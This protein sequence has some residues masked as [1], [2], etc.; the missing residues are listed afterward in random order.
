MSA[1]STSTPTSLFPSL[2][3]STLLKGSSTAASTSEPFIKFGAESLADRH[4]AWPSLLVA[5]F[6]HFL[7]L[8]RLTAPSGRSRRGS[9]E[10]GNK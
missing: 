4:L 5:S 3:R 8:M 2:R 7:L 6:I 1:L 10:W 9:A